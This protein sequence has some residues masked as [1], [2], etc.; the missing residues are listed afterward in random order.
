M[1][2]I[3]KIEKRKFNLFK[4]EMT[5]KLGSECKFYAPKIKVSTIRKNRKIEK[6]FFFTGG[7]Y[8]LSS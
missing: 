7:L 1:W 3:I 5:K 4:S 6:N 8:F 2:T